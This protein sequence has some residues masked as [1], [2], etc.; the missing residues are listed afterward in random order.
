M[1]ASFRVKKFSFEIIMPTSVHSARI[2]PYA[3]GSEGSDGNGCVFF[4]HTPCIFQ[5][6]LN[7]TPCS[8]NEK[9]LFVFHFIRHF[10]KPGRLT[11]FSKG[12]M[13]VV[14]NESNPGS[15]NVFC[16]DPS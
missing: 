15:Q 4:S 9:Q 10:R 13:C 7:L 3:N 12:L 16:F 11:L 6:I 14:R 1:V 2:K 5:N 8:F